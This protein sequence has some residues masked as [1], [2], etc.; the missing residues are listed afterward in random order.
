MERVA[1]LLVLCGPNDRFRRMGEIPAR[2]IRRRIGLHPGDVVQQF[3]AELLHGKADRMNHMAR[4]ANPN[5]AVGLERALARREPRTIEFV[6]GIGPARFVPVA[7]IYAHHAPR[8]AGDAVVG[9]KIRRVGE[10]QVHAA[11]RN[12]RENLQAVALINL[13]VVRSVVEHGL[14]QPQCGQSG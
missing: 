1:A 4:P 10:N 14:R 3:E 9:E 13:D 2:K 7:L 12:R 5:L 11:F 8:V 6:V